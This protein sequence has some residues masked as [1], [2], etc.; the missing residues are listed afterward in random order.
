MILCQYLLETAVVP[1]IFL[2]PFISSQQY[3]PA[4]PF[5]L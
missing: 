3:H 4:T 5:S 1:F 2:F